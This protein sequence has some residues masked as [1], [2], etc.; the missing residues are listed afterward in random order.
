MVGVAGVAKV[1]EA[2][3]M[4]V[5]EETI[6]TLMLATAGWDGVMGEVRVGEAKVGLVAM[7][8]V[9][10]EIGSSLVGDLTSRVVGDRGE[11]AFLPLAS[12][13]V[14]GEKLG[15]VKKLMLSAL[16]RLVSSG[17]TEE[18]AG[19]APGVALGREPGVVICYRICMQICIR[20]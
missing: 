10:G 18:V 3:E 8:G 4:E 7:T 6:S 16:V 5:T 17:G 2:E 12:V 1:G 11:E 15:S 20:L 9:G 14:L 19:A 13:V